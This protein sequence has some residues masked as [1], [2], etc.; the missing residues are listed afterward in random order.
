MEGRTNLQLAK[1]KASRLEIAKQ[2][3]QQSASKYDYVKVKVLLGEDRNHYYVLSRFLISRSLTVTKIP[4]LK[5]NKIA[6]ELK[7]Y[8]VDSGLLEI[9][10]VI[11][12]MDLCHVPLRQGTAGKA[13][14]A[15]ERWRRHHQLRQ[16]TRNVCMR[17]ATTWPEGGG[18]I[19]DHW[20]QELAT[21]ACGGPDAVAAHISAD[22][23]Q[24]L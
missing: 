14:A 2:D 20:E 15:Q 1:E 18:S 22:C 13:H 8:L 6:L 21:P 17:C 24:C 16:L 9:P 5:A 23:W 3:G 12:L 11:K 7:K 10:Q 4:H 19:P